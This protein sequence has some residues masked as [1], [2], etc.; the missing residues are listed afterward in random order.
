MGKYKV[1]D[2]YRLSLTIDYAFKKFFVTRPDLLIDFL[3]AVFHKIDN[4]IIESLSIQNPELP[5]EAIDDKNAIM[6]IHAK[7]TRGHAINIEMQAHE[8]AQFT[9]RAAFYAFRLYLQGIE[10]GEEHSKIPPVFSVNLL[11]FNLFPGL[12]YH[13]CF[14]ILDV[15]EPSISM[16]DDI[17]FHFIELKKLEASIDDLNDPLEIWATFIRFSGIL[18]EEEMQELESKNPLQKK[19]HETLD[20]ISQDSESRLAYDRRKSAL[21]FYEKTLDK[22]FADGKIEGKAEGKLEGKIEGITEGKI[23]VARK[24][25]DKDFPWLDILDIT[26][27]SDKDLRQAE[28]L[29]ET[30]SQQ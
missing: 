16:M 7:D 1:H 3:N 6:D 11:D 8:I 17:E 4:F 18:S 2:S 14:R 27:L 30:D 23:E 15:F 24:M 10:K 19:A 20:E 22:K 29:P 12:N 9:K 5:G 21:F 13:R 26:G 25:L 28:L